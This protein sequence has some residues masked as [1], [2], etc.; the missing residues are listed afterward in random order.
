MQALTVAAKVKVCKSTISFQAG[1][2][3]DQEERTITVP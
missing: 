2:H 1:S 3:E